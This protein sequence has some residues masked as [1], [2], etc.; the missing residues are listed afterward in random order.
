M[1]MGIRKI[2]RDGCIEY[3]TDEKEARRLDFKR[4]RFIVK[5]K[6][7]ALAKSYRLGAIWNML[8]PLILSLVYLFVFSVIR[9]RPE[10]GSLMIGL[11][12]IK[13]LQQNLVYG[14]TSS[15]D[16]TAGIKIER[17]RT[18]AI[19]MAE[20]MYVI[21][22]SFYVSLGTLGV[23]FILNASW[24]IFPIFP[25]ICVLNGLTWYS[26]GKM[27]SAVVIRIPDFGKFVSYF[28]MLMF[29]MSPALYPLTETTGLHREICRYNPF[30]YFSEPSRAAAYGEE[31]INEL[32]PEVAVILS[33][34]VTL[35]LFIGLR[36]IDK[37]RWEGSVW[38]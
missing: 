15:L 18:R 14:A 35:L 34:A 28:G 7:L 1:N 5:K 6:D 33:V 22:Q 32:I 12:L 21:Q 25:I 10:P 8:D 26:I 17:V 37:Q 3:P 9:Y 36:N 30:S 23:L 31:G 20:L 38:F 16:Y 11:A 19:I 27:L 13:G 2:S 29:F 4:A 24:P